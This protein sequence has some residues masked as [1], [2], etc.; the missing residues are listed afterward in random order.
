MT[1][2]LSCFVRCCRSASTIYVVDPTFGSPVSTCEP[3]RVMSSPDTVVSKRWS[4]DRVG[5]L[6]W[7]TSMYRRLW[8]SVLLK[9]LD[10]ESCGSGSVST[11]LLCVADSHMSSQIVFYLFRPIIQEMQSRSN[12]SSKWYPTRCWLPSSRDSNFEEREVRYRIFSQ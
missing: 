12:L 5:I 10:A 9:I 2:Q 7:S 4:V 3:N 8:C 6:H 1:S 11:F